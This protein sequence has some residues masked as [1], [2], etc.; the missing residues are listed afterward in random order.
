MSMYRQL[1]LAIVASTLLALFGSLLASTLSARAYLSEQLAMK[2]TDNASALAL[3]LSQRHP[4]AVEVELTVAALFDSGH[5]ELIRITDPF[6]QTMV[7]RKAPGADTDVPE[8]FTR[9]LPIP[10]VAGR[11]QISDGWKQFGT[12]ELISH[13]RFAYQALWKSV[14][15]TVAALIAAGLVGGYLGGLVLHRLRKPL[16]AVI[17]Q[18]QAITERRFI[19]IAE[20]KV[21]ELKRLA[22]AM[23]AT[24][25]RLKSMFEE[26]AARLESVRREANCDL[27]TGLANRGHF[28]A[29]FK[30][31]LCDENSLG[32]SLI[33]LRLADLADINRRL[34]RSDTDD[35]LRKAGAVLAKAAATQPDAF[36]ARL[37]GADFALLLPDVQNP[38]QVAESLLEA[39]VTEAA[40]YVGRE[41]TAHIGVGRYL[42]GS[43]LV[44]VISQ[45]DAALASAENQGGNSIVEASLVTDEETPRSSEQWS[46]LIQRALDHGWVRLVSFPVAD[47][48]GQILHRECPLRLMLDEHGDWLPAG[49][50]LPMAERLRLTSQLDLAAVDLGLRQ[51]AD[52]PALP[53]LAINLSASSVADA[54]FCRHVVARLQQQPQVAARLW[55][56]IAE[57][58]ALKQFDS[59]RQFVRTLKGTGCRVGVEHFGH[60]F[61]Q[62]G[63][64]H[65]L[66]LDY[67]KIDATF[68]R[69]LNDNPG[70]QA[71][72]NGLATIAHAIGLVVIAEGVA[73]EEERDALAAAGI[74]G[75]TGPA[76]RDV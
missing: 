54:A 70:N 42:C 47:M 35:L 64:L 50:F 29:F 17:D 72:L 61:S 73:T 4:D 15:Q 67:L 13:T 45:V 19:T 63:L 34:G 7:E 74:D 49:R 68:I 44:Q 10:S 28:L 69:G 22:A 66:G 20:P 76:I 18:A 25:L 41:P 14:W 30:K 48:T 5:Y 58:G 27:L 23:N 62:I 31:Q 21:P 6:G 71:F 38:R 60:Q 12:I 33:V 59:F 51:L 40:P 65:D 3:S 24:V 75:A 2:N 1:W 55:L 26:E 56:E 16:K 43:D 46:Q 11:A 53:G 37:N 32:G 39:L 9:L 8:W 57:T 52:E 36:A